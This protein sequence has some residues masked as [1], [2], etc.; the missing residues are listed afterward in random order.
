MGTVSREEMGLFALAMG[1]GVNLDISGQGLPLRF[2]LERS[3]CF[4]PGS[5]PAQ[6]H[7]PRATQE[8]VCKERWV[9]L[10]L[11][12][13]CNVGLLCVSWTDAEREA[14]GT[15]WVVQ[16]HAESKASLLCSRSLSLQGFAWTSLLLLCFLGEGRR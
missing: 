3:L 14:V 10:G 7:L 16:G 2:L 8:W 11:Q 1:L 12:G 4:Q 15:S 5:W 6:T 13:T 9:R